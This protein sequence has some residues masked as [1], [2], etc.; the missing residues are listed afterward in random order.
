MERQ[1]SRQAITLYVK[2][3]KRHDKSVRPSKKCQ[4]AYNQIAAILNQS[5]DVR[6]AGE[7]V[8]LPVMLPSEDIG[9]IG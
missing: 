7:Q 1:F 4:L 2:K 6:Y 3:L 5:E 8:S 9:L